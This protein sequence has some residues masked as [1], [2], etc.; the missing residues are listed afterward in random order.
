M[1]NINLKEDDVTIEVIGSHKVWALTSMIHFKKANILSVAKTGQEIRP[2]WL[3]RVGTAVPG[4][5]CAGTLYGWHR[6]EFWDR[7]K[8]GHGIC[9]DLVN[10]AYTRIVVDVMDP[11][12]T[13]RRLL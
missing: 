8:K 7:T 4:Y 13:I 10:A 2:P 1:V 3:L 6:K 9:I 12:E 11:D 5:I